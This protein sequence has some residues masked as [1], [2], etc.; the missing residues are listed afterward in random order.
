MDRRCVWDWL[1]EVYRHPTVAF[2][3]YSDKQ[4][5]EFA[6]DAFVLLK[7]QQAVI[8]CLKRKVKQYEFEK[9]WDECPDR[10]GGGGW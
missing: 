10:M 3:T 7:E 8:E 1:N 6:H 2:N 9:G 4:Q 5:I